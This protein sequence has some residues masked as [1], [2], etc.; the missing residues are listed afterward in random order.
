MINS[1]LDAWIA[2]DEVTA[3][4]TVPLQIA[5]QFLKT[6]HARHFLTRDRTSLARVHL[7]WAVPTAI[8]H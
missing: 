4:S 7:G 8:R 6:Y 1:H 3:V 5:I 2:H